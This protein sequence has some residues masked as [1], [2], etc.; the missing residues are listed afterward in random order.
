[1]LVSVLELTRNKQKKESKSSNLFQFL[2]TINLW[3]GWAKQIC[4]YP[5]IVPNIDHINGTVE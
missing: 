5:S 3:L 1:M 4:Y 2:F